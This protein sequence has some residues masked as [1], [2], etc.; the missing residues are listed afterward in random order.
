MHLVLKQS[1][2]KGSIAFLE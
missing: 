1:I 2:T